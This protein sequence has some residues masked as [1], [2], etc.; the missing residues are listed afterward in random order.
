MVAAKSSCSMSRPVRLT[1]VLVAAAA[2]TLVDEQLC[3][4]YYTGRG[5]C[6]ALRDATSSRR[7]GPLQALTLGAQSAPALVFLHGWPSTAAL[8]ANQFEWFCLDGRFF[9]VAPSWIDFHPD[10]AEADVSLHHWDAQVDAFAAALSALGLDRFVL[11]AHDFGAVLAYQFAYRFPQRVQMLVTLDVGNDPTGNGTALS[12]EATLSQLPSYQQR[13]IEAYVEGN[14]AAMQ[15]HV[16]SMGALF[17][18]CALHRCII[19]PGQTAGIGARTGWPYHV[20]SRTDVHWQERLAP[21]V[22]PSAWEFRL[23]PTFPPQV[24]LLYLW[25]SGLFHSQVLFAFFSHW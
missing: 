10:L 5:N 11:V 15:R 9:C 21:G 6:T 18:P 2:D 4:V 22:A 3:Q 1:A 13:N 24:P 16:D 25:G 12:T 19:A 20:I 14:D 17:G 23:T 8:F 7:A